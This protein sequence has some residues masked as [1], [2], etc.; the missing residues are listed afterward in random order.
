MAMRVA[1]TFLG[2]FHDLFDL[3]IGHALIGADDHEKILFVGKLF[4][5]SVPAASDAWSSTVASLTASSPL[6][7]K[8]IVMF[9]SLLSAVNAFG[10]F[11]SNPGRF[12][13]GEVASRMM[14]S[15][16]DTSMTGM[17]LTP[18]NGTGSSL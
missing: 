4:A 13:I 12:R 9:F 3:A 11:T 10:S 8:L 6:T 2:L 17:M 1:P 14:S 18:D 15:T 5:D 16:S 7:D